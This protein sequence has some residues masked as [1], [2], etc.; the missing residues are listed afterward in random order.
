[1]YYIHCICDLCL[2]LQLTVMLVPSWLEGRRLSWTQQWKHNKCIILH[3]YYTTGTCTCIIISIYL[4]VHVYT[5]H[6]DTP[7]RISYMY[8]MSMYVFNILHNARKHVCLSYIRII[9]HVQSLRTCTYMSIMYMYI[10]HCT[11]QESTGIDIQ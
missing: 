2:Q 8:D 4:H 10:I 7:L 9:I 11:M 6:Y 3:V 5:H 1:M